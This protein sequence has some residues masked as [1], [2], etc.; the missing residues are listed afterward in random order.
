MESSLK[1][2]QQDALE[3]QVARL[4]MEERSLAPKAASA[5]APWAV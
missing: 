1:P 4:E 3:R 2:E 5:C